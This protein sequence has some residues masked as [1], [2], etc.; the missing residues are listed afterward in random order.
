MRSGRHQERLEKYYKVVHDTI[1]KYQVSWV[2]LG[3]RAPSVV[4]LVLAFLTLITCARK[5]DNTTGVRSG[6]QSCGMAICILQ[7]NES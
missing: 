2:M 1:L 3:P 4:I 7:L 6:L 5:L